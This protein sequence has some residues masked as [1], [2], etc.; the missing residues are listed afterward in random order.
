MFFRHENLVCAL[1][2]RLRSRLCAYFMCLALGRRNHLKRVGL[3]GFDHSSTQ[4][5]GLLTFTW[6]W[7]DGVTFLGLPS[8]SSELD[9][10]TEPE[11]STGLGHT[12]ART[13][14]RRRFDS[15]LESEP[16][17]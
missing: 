14:L 8:S 4:S 2:A 5:Q 6:R 1:D 16:I 17:C 15:G 9:P 13:A 3:S 11:K 12:I 10:S 7:R